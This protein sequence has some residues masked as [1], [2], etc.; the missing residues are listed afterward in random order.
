MYLDTRLTMFSDMDSFNRAN[1]RLLLEYG[2]TGDIMAKTRTSAISSPIEHPSDGRVLMVVTDVY[3]H[4]RSRKISIKKR[5]LSAE[6]AGIK[7]AAVWDKDGF[8][9]ISPIRKRPRKSLYRR[10]MSV[11]GL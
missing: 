3:D 7:T 9:P 11:F 6:R 1:E 10:V 4:I 2:Y 8:F 5:L